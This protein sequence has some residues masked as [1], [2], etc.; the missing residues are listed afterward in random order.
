MSKEKGKI[1]PS[2]VSAGNESSSSTYSP[3]V[4]IYEES[5]GTTVLVVEMPGVSKDG[6]NID[7]DKGVLAISADGRRQSVLEQSDMTYQGFETGQYFRAFALSDEV[8]RD[9]IDAKMEDGVLVLRLP[10]AEAVS[11]KKIEIK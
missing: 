6:V 7:V 2:S 1:Q 11:T 9:A 3:V 4:D 8:D 5:D 10:K